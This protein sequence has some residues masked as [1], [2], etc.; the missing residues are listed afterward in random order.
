M[1]RRKKQIGELAQAAGFVGH[2]VVRETGHFIVDFITDHG[3]KVR[4]VMAKTP[5]D[6]RADKNKL[7][8]LKRLLKTKGH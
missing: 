6:G 5:S 8:Q 2:E 1:N 7:A 4:A 3:T